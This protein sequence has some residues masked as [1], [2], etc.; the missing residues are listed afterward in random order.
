[1]AGSITV[2]SITLDSDNT[3]RIL[4]N[5]GATLVSA[6]GTG[7]V[8]GIANNAVTSS[9]I[10][11]V[12][13]SA[14]SGVIT[15]GQ[16]ATSLNL[17]TNNVQVASIQSATGT[18]AITFAAN[19]QVTLANTPLQL[20]GGQIQ[21]PATQIA[22]S[23]ANTLDDY[24]EGDYT[25]TILDGVTSV[26]YSTQTGR[27]T[28]I[29]NL[30]YVSTRLI[31]SGGTTNGNVLTISLPFTI[32]ST[33]N[34]FAVGGVYSN[35]LA[36]NGQNLFVLGRPATAQ[37]EC[38]VQAATNIGGFTGTNYGTSGDISFTIAYRV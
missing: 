7:I 2:S 13:N 17:A 10:A 15:A 4:S 14:I 23:D 37:I 24:E 8:S 32:A 33:T 19:G 29:G 31:I 16:L 36:S 34:L 30:V 35:V 20:T 11:S 9:M 26:S 6:N 27:Y 21:F 3:F 28:K 1:M 25:P 5:T 38:Y 18:P 12:S 22:S